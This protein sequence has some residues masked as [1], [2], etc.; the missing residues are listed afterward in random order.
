MKTYARIVTDPITKVE[1]VA[2]VIDPATDTVGNEIPIANR[3]TAQFVATLVD[4]T[5]ASPQPQQNWVYANDAF[6]AP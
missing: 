6:S 1:L 3:F 4:V 5:S 2:E